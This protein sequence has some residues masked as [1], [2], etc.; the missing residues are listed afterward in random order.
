VLLRHLGS[1]FETHANIRISFLHQALSYIL[2][3]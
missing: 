3:L 1:E 2:L